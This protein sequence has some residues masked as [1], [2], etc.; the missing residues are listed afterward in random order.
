MNKPNSVWTIRLILII[1][2]I[3]S[4]ISIH[5]AWTTGWGSGNLAGGFTW[6]WLAILALFVTEGIAGIILLGIT[7]SGAWM[8][9]SIQLKR[10][11]GWLQQ[12][13]YWNLIP[14]M[15]LVFFFVWI[16]YG[17]EL[18][19]MN[20][21]NMRLWLLWNVILAGTIII[22][23]LRRKGQF[24]GSFFGS[25]L[26]FSAYFRI[27][28]FIPE[29]QTTP[30]SLGWSEGSRYFYGSLFFARSIYG[31]LLPLPILHPTR[32]LMQAVPFF[33]TLPIWFHRLWQVILWIGC[34]AL[35][36]WLLVRRL[37]LENK[38]RALLVGLFGFVFLFQGPVYYHLILCTVPVLAW[39][40]LRKPWRS[41]IV[42]VA[43][44]IWAGISR[45]NWYPVPGLL[46]AVLFILETPYSKQDW[47]KY[48]SLPFL[49]TLIGTI[50]A[51]LTN[52]IYKGL[53]GNSPEVFDS[54]L[55][56]PLLWNRLLPN[57]TYPPG[58]LKGAVYAILPVMILLT[59]MVF[60]KRRNWHP[61]RLLMLG[62]IL[63][64]FIAGGIIVSV[65][66]GGGSNLHNLDAALF[67]LVVIG[68]YIFFDRFNPDMEKVVQFNIS[69]L[70]VGLVVLLPGL[71]FL[72]SGYPIAMPS[73][74]TTTRV[75]E[76][77]QQYLDENPGNALFLS[78]RHLI[79]FNYVHPIKFEP[80]YEKVW[81]MEMAMA[82]NASYLE[83]FYDD[84]NHQRFSIIISDEFNQMI[85]NRD[86][87]FS[88]ENN[89]W[90]QRVEI[91]VSESYHSVVRLKE[92]GLEIWL[93]G[94]QP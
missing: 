18:A 19:S 28:L 56:S 85:Q 66:I 74:E 3:L 14:L 20:A 34:N 38:Y 15:G 35:A 53:S 13:K 42:V 11:A 73:N 91:P 62:G 32:Y 45:I 12:M 54:A 58:I 25:V 82:G 69:W 72:N 68:V 70:W 41:L 93:P 27:I 40:D 80:E 50:S 63:G 67:F 77:I 46:A 1:N 61:L 33:F 2:L 4:I 65:K 60:N 88:E 57:S 75:I 90:V 89:A 7:A 24:I 6:F 64:V 10:L 55:Q 52:H 37:K 39:F 44:S 47:L 76:T 48:F 78:E 30:L 23:G 22:H 86:R 81:L 43:A 29:I 59:I 5:Y 79:T 8:K 17:A 51:W 87:A 31:E 92:A 36:I 49:W 9:I 21:P 71:Q 84:L 94:L 83:K 16:I 26:I